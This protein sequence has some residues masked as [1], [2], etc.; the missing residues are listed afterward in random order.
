[1]VVD[2]RELYLRASRAVLRD[3]EVS[4]RE[5]KLLGRLRVWLGIPAEPAARLLEEARE[6][7]PEDTGGGEL[8][9][10][11][12]V[13]GVV[14][15]ARAG[16]R[17][18]SRGE[19]TLLE[20]LAATFE[21]SSF[22][23]GKWLG[24]G[25]D[26]TPRS[27]APPSEG[28]PD[29][30]NAGNPIAALFLFSIGVWVALPAYLWT[31]LAPESFPLL[32]SDDAWQFALLFVLVGYSAASQGRDGLIAFCWERP[33]LRLFF[34]LGTASLAGVLTWRS[35]RFLLV[36]QMSGPVRL[37]ACLIGLPLVWWF[38]AKPALLA[39]VY[40]ADRHRAGAFSR[41]LG[42][43][44][45]TDEPDHSMWSQAEGFFRMFDGR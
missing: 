37:G 8:D 20:Q 15:G 11:A 28:E 7:L 39:L 30:D 19:V 25:E 44:D 18:L 10:V 4:R 24:K 26:S 31:V 43:G 9:P 40:A 14:E 35:V 38:L 45:V 34:A 12:F 2:P 5:E 36:F 42:A 33:A 3:G 1:V 32:D 21:V 17:V 13:R 23:L 22:E 16:G 6:S 29:Q 27:P 41:A